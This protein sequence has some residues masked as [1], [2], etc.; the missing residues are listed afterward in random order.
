VGYPE[1]MRLKIN[2]QPV[3]IPLSKNPYSIRIILN[4]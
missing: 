2:E 4:N 1:G 3:E